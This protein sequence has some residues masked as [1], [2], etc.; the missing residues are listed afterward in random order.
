[1][2]SMQ[3]VI[4]VPPSKA[5]IS[6]SRTARDLATPGAYGIDFKLISIS[7]SVVFFGLFLPSE[8]AFGAVLKPC[9]R[10]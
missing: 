2:N 8:E 10:V 4:R 6:E 3:I 7:R 5:R 1:M 9:D